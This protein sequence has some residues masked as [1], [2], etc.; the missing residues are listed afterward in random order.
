MNVALASIFTSAVV[1]EGFQ[2]IVNHGVLRFERLPQAE[3]RTITPCVPHG[4]MAHGALSI[5]QAETLIYAA[6][7]HARDLPGEFAAIDKGCALEA[8]SEGASY[9]MGYFLGNG[10]GAGKGR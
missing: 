3:V 8:A 9:R 4:A 6:S 2:R 5:A 10:T 1:E 7:A